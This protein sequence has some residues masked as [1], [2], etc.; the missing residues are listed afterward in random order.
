MM[1][2]C[3]KTRS[4]DD[5][6][7]QVVAEQEEDGPLVIRLSDSL[8]WMDAWATLN[9]ERLEVFKSLRCAL[10]PSGLELSRPLFPY[11]LFLAV[12]GGATIRPGRRSPVPSSGSSSRKSRASHHGPT[13]STLTDPAS[14]R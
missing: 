11:K 5:K 6:L 10:P 14:F 7:P 9:G 13:R 1:T 3:G 12:C 8:N 2:V 4:A